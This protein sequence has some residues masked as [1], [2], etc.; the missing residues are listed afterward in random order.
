MFKLLFIIIMSRF[1]AIHRILM[2]EKQRMKE[3]MYHIEV[4]N[5]IIRNRENI[6]S[7]RKQVN[8]LIVY[9]EKSKSIISL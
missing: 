8:Q 4:K 2:S 1:Y 6:E 5:E 3:M 9:K 7:L